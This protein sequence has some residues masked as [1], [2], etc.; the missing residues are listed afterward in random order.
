MGRVLNTWSLYRTK[1]NP[2]MRKKMAASRVMVLKSDRRLLKLTMVEV[3]DLSCQENVVRVRVF[4]K[5]HS[6]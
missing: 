1:P 5:K 6:E 3:E 2:R 4:T